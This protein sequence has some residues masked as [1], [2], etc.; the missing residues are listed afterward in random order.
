[1]QKEHR[2]SYSLG[3]VSCRFPLGVKDWKL[4]F[5]AELDPDDRYR[6]KPSIPTGPPE[7]PTM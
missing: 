2:P 4:P 5:T 3:A 1:M 7:G 6:L